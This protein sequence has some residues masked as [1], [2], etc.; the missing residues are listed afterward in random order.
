MS[1]KVKALRD[2]TGLSVYECMKI[3][4]TEELEE[5]INN[6]DVGEDLK[7]ILKELIK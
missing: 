2:K 4:K 3:I 1:D 7:S 6:L 5:R